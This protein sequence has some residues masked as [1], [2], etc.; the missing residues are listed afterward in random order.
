M[1]NAWFATLDAK[2]ALATTLA[3][4]AVPLITFL[5]AF[6][7]KTAPLDFTTH[8]TMEL[9]SVEFVLKLATHVMQM[10]VLPV[11]QEPSYLINSALLNVPIITHPV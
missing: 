10:D 11:Q 4:V 6:A 7:I 3:S 9:M 8:R 5:K 2:I 1:V